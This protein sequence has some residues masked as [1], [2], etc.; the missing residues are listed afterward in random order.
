MLGLVAVVLA[1][2]TGAEDGP[3]TTGTA[4]AAPAATS[5]PTAAGDGDVVTI[6]AGE[7]FL[8]APDVVPAG[9][10][11]F[12]LDNVGGLAHHAQVVQIPSS[13]VETF[14][15]DDTYGQ[16]MNEATRLGG[17]ATVEPQSISAPVTT[18][19]QPGTYGLL[20]MLVTDGSQHSARGMRTT[21]V[22]EGERAEPA[23]PATDATIGLDEFAFDVPGDFDGSGSFLVQNNGSL[24]HEMSLLEVADGASRREV[25]SE[26]AA[27]DGAVPAPDT[28]TFAG[29]VQSLR[30]RK[31][32][33]IDL[34]LEAGTYALVCSVLEGQ[35]RHWQE[36]MLEVVEVT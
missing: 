33:V 30:F 9:E 11:T 34:D 5:E 35:T 36:G 28:I 3:P 26:L 23:E 24:D 22:V 17:P 19:L 18:T 31:T 4:T 1:G 7:F 29:G 14:Q 15:D 10:V 2:C 6:D 12:V 8:D 16:I 20:C 32:Q 27:W 21:F 25:R 13:S